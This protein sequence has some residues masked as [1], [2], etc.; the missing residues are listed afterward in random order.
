MKFHKLLLPFMLA[1]ILL[2]G[3]SEK[4]IKDKIH[5]NLDKDSNISYEV[6]DVANVDFLEDTRYQAYCIK[7]FMEEAFRGQDYLFFS[8]NAGVVMQ[9]MDSDIFCGDIDGD[10]AN[11]MVF[12]AT[13][14]SGVQTLYLYVLEVEN[15]KISISSKTGF[16]YE[17]TQDV[18]DFRISKCEIKK[19][20]IDFA[21]ENK[22]LKLV[23]NENGLV[24][25][26]VDNQAVDVIC[27]SKQQLEACLLS[28]QELYQTMIT[29]EG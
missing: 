19:N 20:E 28:A 24:K 5:V 6:D 7:Y 22:K 11:E 16:G 14:G 21:I 13:E 1:F 15:D 23:F 26:E 17:I 10:G 4:T 3:C 18:S 27:A 2:C 8:D 29:I 12:A 9:D 25:G